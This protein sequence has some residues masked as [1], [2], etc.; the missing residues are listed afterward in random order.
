[1][2]R[3]RAK[4]FR[5]RKTRGVKGRQRRST[6][7]NRRIRPA[8]AHRERTS[9]ERNYQPEFNASEI[10]YEPSDDPRGEIRY[11]EYAPGDGYVHPV[12]I[13]DIKKRLAQFPKQFLQNVEVIQLSPMT[14]KRMLFPCYGMQ[15]GTTVYLYP[16][17]E[18][19]VEYYAGPP[20]P[21]LMIDTKMY[22]G[23]WKQ[24]GDEWELEWT[25]RTIR[26]F[27]LNSILI[28]EIGH[29]ND[30]RNQSYT[31]RERFADWFAIEYGYRQSRGRI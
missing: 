25:P 27:Y 24:Y 21:Q 13:R 30:P 7:R 1:M 17:E 5:S 6:N 29:A 4:S 22:G 16:I 15:W 14:R 2:T 8:S 20:R 10:W 31:D 18:S 3:H 28:H 19:L 26:D 12:S 11:V 23:R 9:G